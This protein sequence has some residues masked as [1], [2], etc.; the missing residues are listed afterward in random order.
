MMSIVGGEQESSNRVGNHRPRN[1]FVIC[2]V[3]SAEQV[4]MK[5]NG[6]HWF[7]VAFQKMA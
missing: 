2:I 4:T 5:P 7:A 6:H 3:N 1:D